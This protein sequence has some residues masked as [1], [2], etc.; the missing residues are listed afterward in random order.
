M[1]AVRIHSFG[2]PEML[3]LDEIPYLHPRPANTWS[4]SGEPGQPRSTTRSAKRLSEDYAGAVAH[5]LGQGCLRIIQ[6][7]ANGGVDHAGMPFTPCSTGISRLCRVRLRVGRAVRTEAASLSIAEAGAVP[8]AAL[9]ACREFSTTE[10][11]RLGRPSSSSG[12]GW[13][14]HL[15]SNSQEQGRARHC[16]GL[17]QEYGFRA[18]VGSGHRHRL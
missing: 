5:H 12:F 8:L 13:S 4:E 11:W 14:R 1:K 15:R 3:A 7:S 2:G 6:S 17:R 18:P 16:D 9:T 10:N